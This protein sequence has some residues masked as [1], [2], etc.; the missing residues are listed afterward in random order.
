MAKKSETRKP[1]RAVKPAAR[2]KAPARPK[3]RKAAAKPAPRGLPVVVCCKWGRPFPAE[4]VNMLC[5]AVADNL[6]EPHRFVCLT[7]DAKGLIPEVEAIALPEMGIVEER[8][9]F[10]CWPKLSIFKPGI[11]GEDEIPV[12]Y[13]DL[14]IM[15]LR[16]IDAYFQRIRELRGLNVQREWNPTLWSLAPLALRP[17]RGVQGSVIG[18]YPSEQRHLYDRFVADPDAVYATC[19]DDQVFITRESPQRRYWP[20]DWS[21]SFKWHCVKYFP[22]NRIFPKIRKPAKSKVLVFHGS[23]RPADL[24][25]NDRSRWG[26]KRK[27]GY[28]PVDWVKEYWTR[29]GDKAQ[30]RR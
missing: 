22:L 7:D 27:F 25:R 20:F 12:L 8:K 11:F 13:L 2:A 16:P 26:T 24:V 4:Y 15:I 5:R 21:S 19:N 28:G 1:A 3:A 29:Y 14:D 23:P 18:F 30:P 9:G 17:D 6:S 10:G